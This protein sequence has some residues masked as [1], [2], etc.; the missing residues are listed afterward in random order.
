MN[1]QGQESSSRF[2]VYLERA[3]TVGDWKS[4]ETLLPEI[5]KWAEVRGHRT[6]CFQIQSLCADL[7][8]RKALAV[9]EG[10]NGS[11]S[12]PR[13][14]HPWE[15]GRGVMALEDLLKRLAHAE[16]LGHEEERNLELDWGSSFFLGLEPRDSDWVFDMDLEIR[17]SLK[18]AI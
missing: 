1:Q 11:Q 3:L 8:Q 10:G 15:E 6:L 5:L 2:S 7:Q 12:S 14:A 16:W 17:P 18:G 4:V 13:V 9:G